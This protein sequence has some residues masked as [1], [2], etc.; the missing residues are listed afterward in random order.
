MNRRDALKRLAL[1][2]AVATTGPLLMSSP[3]FADGGTTGSRPVGVP[4]A[5]TVTVNQFLAGR[6]Y[7]LNLSVTGATC[8]FGTPATARVE[9][10]YTVVANPLPL[11]LSPGPGTTY[12]LGSGIGFFVYDFAGI[13]T[14]TQLT[15]Q[16]HAR[17][18]CDNRTGGAAWTC[19][20][21]EIPL[22]FDGATFQIGTITSVTPPPS[23][24]SPPPSP[25]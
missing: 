20:S 24:D 18:V 14:G 3:A 11:G 22:Q 10:F 17:W 4:S 6:F 13:P 16:F 5:P 1:A 9:R 8:P 12:G 15:V 25:S 19:R 7:R 23:C 21:W 2:G